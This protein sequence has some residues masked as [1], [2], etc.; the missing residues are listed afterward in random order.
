MTLYAM[1]RTSDDR[2]KTG[3]YT[4]NGR[5][6]VSEDPEELRQHAVLNAEVREFPAPIPLQEWLPAP[7]GTRDAGA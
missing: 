1:W 2:T 7:R 3:W 5:V 6:I 4:T